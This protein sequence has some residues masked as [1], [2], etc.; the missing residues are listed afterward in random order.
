FDLKY[1]NGL[2]LLYNGARGSRIEPCGCRALNLG[3]IDKEAAMVQHIRSKNPNTLYVD[4]GGFFR[5]FT[6]PAIRLQS[7]YML[8]AMAQ[9]QYQVMNIGFPDIRQ[10]MA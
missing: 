5:E 7:W 8:E 3:G 2:T 4:A 1:P 6:D 10:G 9:L